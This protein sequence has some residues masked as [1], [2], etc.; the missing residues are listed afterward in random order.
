MASCPHCQAEHEEHAPSCPD[1]GILLTEPPQPCELHPDEMTLA[2]CAVCQRLVCAECAKHKSRRYLCRDHAS[3]EVIDGHVDVRK[4][5]DP[6]EAE[7]LR[8]CLENEGVPA[9][10]HDQKDHNFTTT[11]GPLAPIKVL[12]PRPYL[13]EARR[14]LEAAD[15]ATSVLGTACPD[16]G[17]AMAPDQTDCPA[18]ASMDPQ[19]DGDQSR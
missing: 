13:D 8:V 17:L 6:M 5:G 10:I 4:V 15:H 19:D 14:I 2:R 11:F 1:C 3:V 18:C 9:W 12:V 16:C 7:L